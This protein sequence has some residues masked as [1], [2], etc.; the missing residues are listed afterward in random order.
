MGTGVVSRLWCAEEG[1]VVDEA[2]GVEVCGDAPV[3]VATEARV[4]VAHTLERCGAR[5]AQLRVRLSDASGVLSGLVVA[6]ANAIAGGGRCGC[7]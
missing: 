4:R 3:G 5:V 1:R 2:R 7:R 6:Q